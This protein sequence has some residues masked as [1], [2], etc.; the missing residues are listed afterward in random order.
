M[1]AQIGRYSIESKIGQGAMGEVYL[2]FDKRIHR[3]VAVKT[4]RLDRI[5]T[6]EARQQA[7]E[8]FLREARFY[9]KLNHRHIAAIYDMGYDETPYLV[10]EFIEGQNLKYIIANNITFSLQKKVAIIAILARALHYAHQRE[11]LHRDIKPANIMLL[12]NGTPKITDFG[13]ARA[14]DMPG[15]DIDP[16]GAQGV[17]GT[18]YYMAPEHIKALDCD[19]RADLFSLGVVSYEW[20]ANGRRPFIGKD[21]QEIIDNI[22]N[23][24][25]KS[26]AD[27]GAT[28]DKLSAIIG[29]T[30]TKNPDSRYENAEA[31]SDAL[32]MYLNS[33]AMAQNITNNPTFDKQS[34]IQRLRQKYIFFADF[35]NNELLTIFKL[36]QNKKYIPGEYIIREDTVGSKMYVITSG[37]VSIQSETEGQSVEIDRLGPGSCVGEMA[38]VDKLERSASVVALEPTQ[39]IAINETVLRLSNPRICLKLYRNLAALLSERL[40]LNDAKYRRLLAKRK[41]GEHG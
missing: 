18:P 20:L 3:K 23:V 33:K 9:G 31:F 15:S 26:L 21:G 38:L 10:M 24:Q 34:I 5:T 37:R 28:D 2:A 17:L 13:I 36:S 32:E 12:K 27:I 29:R 11:I 6:K 40:R 16:N 19:G 30:I 7:A 14:I 8:M 35:T 41:D 22:L 39:A 1:S 25:E 4:I